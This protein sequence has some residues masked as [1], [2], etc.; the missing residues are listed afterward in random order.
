MDL[1][2]IDPLSLD[3]TNDENKDDSKDQEK[4]VSLWEH[5]ALSQIPIK[6][7]RGHTD[8]VSNCHFCF[9]DTRVLTSS[10]DKTA[11]LW[12]S[13]TGA[14]LQVFKGVHKSAITECTLVPKKNRLITASLDKTLVAWDL[15]TGKII[16]TAPHG[17]FVTSCSTTGDGKLVA[18]ASDQENAIYLTNTDTGERVL[19]LK[20]HHKSTITRCRFDPQGQRVAS[21]SNDTTIKLWD[22]V[23]NKTT[24]AI[25]SNHTNVISSCSFNHNGH[26]LC[27]ASWDKTL[28]LWDVHQGTFRSCGG[29]MLSRG[30]EGSISSCVFSNDSSLLVSGAFDRTVAVWDMA[31]FC[32]TL[33][34]KGHLDWVTDVSISAD[35]KWV[36][37]ASKDSTVRLWNIENSEQIPEVIERRKAQGMGFHVLKCE[38][39]GKPFSLSRVETSDLITKCVFCRLKT[40]TRYHPQPPP[41]LSIN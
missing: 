25:N 6:V 41:L 40:P 5:E 38:E 16:W 17:G 18:S 21:V 36:A 26:L 39:C 19:Y 4:S 31:A 2:N 8:A 33:V 34:L 37:S 28:Q 30:H 15:E 29:A 23:S 20:G 14:S 9:D 24:L 32:R 13:D 27:S 11:T 12:D 35:R 3:D 7:F 10:H 22:L 1:K